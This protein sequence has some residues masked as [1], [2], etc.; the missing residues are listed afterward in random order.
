MKQPAKS[1]PIDLGALQDTYNAA[2]KQWLSDSKALEKA[3]TAVDASSE[4]YNQAFNA[5]KSGSRAAIG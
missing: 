4:A 3:Q 5:L 2:K 1:K